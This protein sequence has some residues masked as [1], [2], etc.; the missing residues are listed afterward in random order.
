M[1]KLRP[2]AGAIAVALVSVFAT[3]CVHSR[4]G[5]PV[6]GVTAIPFQIVNNLILIPVRVDRSPPAFFI[7]DTGASAS[8]IDLEFAKRLGLELQGGSDVS[9]SGG[10]VGSSTVE[11]AQVSLSGLDLGDLPDMSGMSLAASGDAL[12]VVRVRLVIPDSPAAAAGIQ[13]GDTLAAVDGV[14]ARTLGLDDIRRMFRKEGRE[15][16]LAL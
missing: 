16:R 14:P 11:K 1:D 6:R 9:T 8:V 3:S 2:I 10:S 7:L 4:D 5:A 15:H 13:A 12:E